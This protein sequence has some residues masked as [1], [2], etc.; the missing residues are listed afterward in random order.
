[1]QVPSSLP[2]RQAFA[3]KPLSGDSRKPRLFWKSLD[4]SPS[5]RRG[6]QALSEWPARGHYERPTQ[7]A[8][9]GLAWP[10]KTGVCGTP[11]TPR[12]NQFCAPDGSWPPGVAKSGDGC[13]GASGFRFPYALPS[14][15]RG[16][17]FLPRQVY[18][19]LDTAAFPGRTAVLETYASYGSSKS[20]AAQSM[21]Y[22]LIRRRATSP[23]AELGVPLLVALQVY[24]F[25]IG[26]RHPVV[27]TAAS[28]DQ[29]RGRLPVMK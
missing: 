26:V 16:F 5:G 1:M 11:K 21:S 14:Q 25:L 6:A 3:R 19:L 12:L 29:T 9:G 15:L 28:P 4:D 20:H 2:G 17:R 27:P 18:L 10:L 23:L 7:G 8:R 22:R 24:Q 13:P